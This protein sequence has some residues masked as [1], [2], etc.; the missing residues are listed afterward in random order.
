VQGGNFNN[1]RGFLAYS[2]DVQ[3]T[4]AYVAYEGSYTDGPFESPGRYRRDN[5]N[6][7][8]TRTLD[9]RQKLGFRVLVGRNDFY[10]SG[11][12]PLDLVA[13]G[14]LDRF[15]YVDPSDSGGVRLTHRI[16]L[17]QPHFHR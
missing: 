9:D 11:Q 14:Q 3:K 16:H 1:A 5:F 15:G 8:Y 12:I 2:P 4:D 10:S 6:A 17:L 13:S 7:N